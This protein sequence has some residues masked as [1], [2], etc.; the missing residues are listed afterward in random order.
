MVQHPGRA[1]PDPAGRRRRGLRAHDA[2]DPASGAKM[3]KTAGNAVWL[4]PERTSP[5][6]YYQF[7]LNTE[8]ADVGRFLRSSRSCRSRR[9]P[10]WSSSA[11]PRSTGQGRTRVRSDAHDARR[12]GGP[13]PRPR[14]AGGSAARAAPNG[15]RSSCASRRASRSCW[16]KRASRHR[17]ARPVARSTRAAS[18]STPRRSARP[19]GEIG[20]AEL[21]AL[22]SLGKRKVRLVL[23]VRRCC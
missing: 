14:R 9:S 2:A 4:D 22:L 21:P 23:R 15:R 13:P 12:R 11:A 3:G 5:Y 7:W 1:R 6:D 10:S 20:P 17:L 18:E 8:D 16:S 19:S